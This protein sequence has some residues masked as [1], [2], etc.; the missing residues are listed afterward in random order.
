MLAGTLV[1]TE[2]PLGWIAHWH[3]SWRGREY[4]WHNR[5]VS[6]DDAFP[7]AV[8]RAVPLVSGHGA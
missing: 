2:A 1:W 3:L 7:N 5:G 8:D 4:R 6:F